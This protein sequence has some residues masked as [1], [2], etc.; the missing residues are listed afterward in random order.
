MKKII[1]FTFVLLTSFSLVFAQELKYVG[2]Y[3]SG[4]F[5]TDGGV[6]EIV[7][8]SPFSQRAYAVNGQSGMLASISY[9]G[10]SF[11]S[12]DIDVKNIIENADPNF[13]Y[14]DM[15]SVSASE[16]GR[17][18]AIALQAEGYNDCGKIALFTVNE[19]GSISL[20]KIYD[21]GI[22]PDM[23]L[24]AGDYVLSADEGE[25]RLGYDEED[26]KGSVT[27]VDLN[28]GTSKTIYFDSFDQKRD[29]LV[30]SGVI[31]KKDSLPSR[32]FEPEYLTV[33]GEKAYVTLQENNAIAVLDLN[34][35]EFVNVFSLGFEDF[36]T[37]C[38]DINKDDETYNPKNYPGL[39]G[40]RMADGIASFERNGVTYLITANEGDSREWG[41]YIN[42]VE[43]DFS[44]ENALSPSGRGY[45]VGGKV[46]FFDS[47][48]Y[49][50]LDD[51]CDYI[52]GS[53]GMSIYTED[54][55]LVYSS[56]DIAEK[57][58]F[59]AFPNYFN[60]SNDNSFIDDR[61]GKK[62]PEAESVAVASVGDNVYAFLA[63]ERT[64]GIIV[65]DVSD[66]NDV[67]YLS[68]INTRDFENIRPGSE[69]YDDGELDKYVTLGDVAPEGLCFVPSSIS[70]IEKDVLLAAYEVSG[71]VS[72]YIFE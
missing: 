16:D 12:D 36:G 3:S 19:D 22:Q 34:S 59:D 17:L 39:Y 30:A 56:S 40:I 23:I 67:K 46:V 5:N 51:G 10:S 61:S 48:D 54:G 57:V 7:T 42:E 31:I 71:T 28:D 65:F 20:S 60:C 50:G 33:S 25:P 72:A 38:V 37:T 63:L 44:K 69:E 9:D 8:Y 18:L 55:S 32:D 27:V 2:T 13:S 14:G 11:Y 58:T 53:R 21:A 15:T 29:E 70:P 24:I 45:D 35:L 43:V 62:G 4:E 49:D 64:G 47:S 68:Y 26:P 52:F 66:V 41:D 1:A 6:M